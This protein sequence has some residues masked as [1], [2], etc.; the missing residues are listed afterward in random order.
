MPLPEVSSSQLV[1]LLCGMAAKYG[2]IRDAQDGVEYGINLF[3]GANAFASNGIYQPG[4]ACDGFTCAT[5]I[6]EIFK[7][8]GFH[9]ID[10]ATWEPRK[11]NE[12]WGK[13]IVCM[14]QATQASQAHVSKVQANISSL[15]VRP[16]EVAASAELPREFHPAP[17][18][19]IVGRADELTAQ[20]GSSCGKPP[21]SIIFKHCVAKY[22]TA[23]RL[24]LGWR[25]CSRRKMGR[26]KLGSHSSFS[27]ETK[28]SGIPRIKCKYSSV[29]GLSNTGSKNLL[30]ASAT[31]LLPESGTQSSAS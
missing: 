19:M 16:E 23:V 21:E 24:S 7:N 20:I 11:V 28:A 18:R 14:L 31:P 15:R 1:A 25:S 22:R 3:A 12:A 30:S 5:L 10:V 29:K 2:N 6:V 9:L 26:Q 13:A 27:I 4:P 8:I 17:Y